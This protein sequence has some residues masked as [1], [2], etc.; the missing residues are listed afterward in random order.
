MISNIVSTLVPVKLTVE[1][2]TLCRRDAT[3]L[4][5]DTTIAIMMNKLGNSV[6]S[7]R[8]EK[9]LKIRFGER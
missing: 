1:I 7:D 6:L 9:L 2:E 5:G 4:S 3:L 8:L